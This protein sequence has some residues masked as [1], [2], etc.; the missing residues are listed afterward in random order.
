MREND[1]GQPLA[2]D[3]SKEPKEE[4]A[5][6]KGTSVQNVLSGTCRSKPSYSHGENTDPNANKIDLSPFLDPFS[7][8]DGLGKKGNNAMENSPPQFL[9]AFCSP[10]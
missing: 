6:G 7:P 9:R 2:L 3:K 8:E 10:C 1:R 5:G 4:N